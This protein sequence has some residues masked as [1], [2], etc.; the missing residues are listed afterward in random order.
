MFQR[1]RFETYEALR[2]LD[3][4]HPDIDGQW[5]LGQM[6][7]WSKWADQTGDLAPVT[8]SDADEFDALGPVTTSVIFF[9]INLG[10]LKLPSESDDWRNFHTT[11]HI[12]DSTLRN[13]FRRAEA[14][15]A[16]AVPGF[17]MTDVFKLVPTTNA[18]KLNTKVREDMA[19]GVDHVGRCAK[20][21]RQEL[22]ICRR[23]AGG[24]APTLVALGKEAFR[25]LT[26]AVPDDRI[27]QVVDELLGDGASR[28][29]VQM[30]HYTF[31][32]GT[33]ESRV[34]VLEPVMRRVLNP[35]PS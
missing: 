28:D 33:H 16:D 9:A 20:I 11:G 19:Q 15:F 14:R 35:R 29:V 2:T 18:G 12:G 6:T 13:S 5:R 1:A 26:G 8:A 27:S 24:A 30:D 7:S 22:E 31:G 34:A 25:W 10:G 32:S 17:Y 21:L 4:S 23:G 3:I